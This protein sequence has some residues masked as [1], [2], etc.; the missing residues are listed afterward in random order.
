MRL[1]CLAYAM[2]R[3]TERHFQSDTA[4]WNFVLRRPPGLPIRG[5]TLPRSKDVDETRPYL[6]VEGAKI[7]DRLA[8]G[9]KILKTTHRC[10]DLASESTESQGSLQPRGGCYLAPYNVGWLLDHR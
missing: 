5:S 10:G 1:Y 9:S 4:T 7:E 3:L 8:P 2:H 6:A